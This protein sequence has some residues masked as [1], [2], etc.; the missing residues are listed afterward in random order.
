GPE[1]RAEVLTFAREPDNGTQ[2]V[3][4]VAGVIAA[5]LEDDAVHR[6]ADPLVGRELLEGV[7]QLDLA[8][9]ARLGLAEYLEDGRVEDVAADDGEVGRRVGGVGLLDQT[10][11]PDDVG[12]LGGLDGGGTVEVDLLGGH[13]HEGDDAAAVL[14]LDVDH[15]LEQGVA[16]VDQVVAEEHGEG[17]I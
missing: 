8:A 1:V 2:V 5:A 15:A 12:V 9:A 7:G 16:R 4:A 17:H 14:R 10:A 13:F 11:D 3:A 6:A